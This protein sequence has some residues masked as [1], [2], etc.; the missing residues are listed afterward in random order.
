MNKDI[1]SFFK[2]KYSS[3][4]ILCG[5]ITFFFI[6]FGALVWFLI[7]VIPKP[8]RATYPC[9]R[10]AFPIASSFVIWLAGVTTSIFS[11]KLISKKFAHVKLIVSLCSI[12]TLVVLIGWFTFTPIGIN[13]ILGADLVDTTFVQAIGFDWTPGESNKPIGIAGGIYP[14]RVVMSHYPEATKWAGNWNKDDDQ[15]WLDKNTD[16]IKVSE[17]LSVTIRKLTGAQKDKVAWNKIFNH[18][19]KTSRGLNNRGYKI[20]EIVAVKVNL[21][22]NSANKLNNYSDASPQM[23][24]AL[25]RQLVYEAGVPQNNII[26]YDARRMIFPA[27]LTSVWREFKDVRFLQAKEPVK[28]QPINPA[29][30]N[31]TG[32][33]AADWVEGI[34]YSA[35]NFKDAKLIPRQIMEAT[36][37]INFAML[38]LHS[39]PYNYMEDGDEGQTGLTM[40]GKNHA[41]SIKGTPEL[42][43]IL[44]TKQEG[45]KNAYS[46]LIDLAASPNL[47]AKTILYLADGLYCGRKWRSY[48][49]HFPNPP[50]NNKT[51][52]Y[53][54][55][56][57]PACLLASFD[58]VAIQ[59]VGLDILYAQSKNNNESTYHNV[60]RILVR[61]NADDFLREMAVPEYAPSGTKYIQNGKPI[62]SLGVFEHW[63]N[64]HTMRYSRNIDPE[65]GKGIEF[66]YIP[67]GSASKK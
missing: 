63:D 22:N 57:W 14:G 19:N 58:G 56:E 62:K 53:E 39:Y 6:G 9:Q 38:K 3:A 16:I 43:P 4:I 5:K 47:G 28:P 41:G 30:N 21:N 66:I 1:F 17:M 60:P 40:T 59:S 46:P 50:F 64:D 8:I 67:L 23:V 29:Y 32:L 34:S 55:P 24:L 11:L 27:I 13:E 42:H 48:P 37:L 25:V 12:A 65:N 36:Y 18:Y 26:V 51:V 49:I 44:D 45:T 54:N 33:E 2:K 52:P 20:G 31:Y 15:W 35:G 61:D 10:A 7:R